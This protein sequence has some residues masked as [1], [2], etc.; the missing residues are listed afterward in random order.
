MAKSNATPAPIVVAP[1]RK[2]AVYAESATITVLKD[3]GKKGASAARFAAYG[4]VGATTTVKSY[5]DAC[6]ALQPTEPRHRWRADLA[7][8]VKRG[9]ISI[10]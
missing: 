9:F 6:L 4:K 5:L 1:A 8:D 10:A 3:A 2:A 7:W